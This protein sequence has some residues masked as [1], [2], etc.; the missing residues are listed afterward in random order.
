MFI[1]KSIKLALLFAGLSALGVQAADTS[2]PASAFTGFEA[3]QPDMPSNDLISYAGH[4]TVIVIFADSLED[5]EFT[6]Q[7]DILRPHAEYLAAQ[8]VVLL[9]DTSPD[10]NGPLRQALRPRGFSLL[11]IN[12]VGT[13]TQ[14]RGTVTDSQRLIRQIDQMP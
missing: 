9:T 5:V 11:L 6:A 2:S 7:L 14:R 8:N 4:A 12:S 13:L 10:A 1:I 3:L